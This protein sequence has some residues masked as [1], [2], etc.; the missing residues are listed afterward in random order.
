MDEVCR[1]GSSQVGERIGAGKVVVQVLSRPGT[2]VEDRVV[3]DDR[4]Y[5]G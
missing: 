2:D 5:V 1:L 4:V 3:A